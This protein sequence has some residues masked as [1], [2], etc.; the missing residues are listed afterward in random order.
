[1]NDWT[2]AAKAVMTINPADFFLSVMPK[3]PD[4]VTKVASLLLNMAPIKEVS[5]YAGKAAN[6]W[7]VSVVLASGNL[8]IN[9]LLGGWRPGGLFPG[10][11]GPT[12]AKLTHHPSANP[13]SWR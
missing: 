4:E 5:F 13:R 3:L 2:L 1:L 8:A 12:G 7:G 10:Q 6:W 11:L 9:A